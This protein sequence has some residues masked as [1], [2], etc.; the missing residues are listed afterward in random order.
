[1]SKKLIK[2]YIPTVQQLKDYGCLPQSLSHHMHQPSLWHLNRRSV[3]KA[4][5]IGLFCTWLPMPFQSLL[6]AGL[7]I[8]LYANLPLSVVLVFITNPVT[9]PPMFY[10]AYYI[11]TGLLG[12]EPQV[13]EFSMTLDWFGHTLK[14]AWKP[15]LAGSLFLAFFSSVMGYLLARGLWRWYIILRWSKRHQKPT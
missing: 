9:I 8:F 14:Q 1:M 12:V 15:L 7:A 11:G 13:I 5:A 4:V 6:A 3:S 2:K 10:F